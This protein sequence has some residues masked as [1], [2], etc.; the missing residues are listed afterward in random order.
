MAL[1]PHQ[2]PKPEELQARLGHLNMVQG[3]ISR[4]AGHSA[5]VKTFTLTIAAAI[6]AVAFEKNLP[7]LLWAGAV[8]TAMFGLLDAY[9]LTVEKCFR[10][11]YEEICARPWSQAFDF[12]IR[13]RRV[14]P[15]DVV[16]SITSI[17]VWGFY[18][19]LLASFAVLPQLLDHVQ[20]PA[21]S[22]EQPT[23]SVALPA[24]PRVGEGPVAASSKERHA[25]RAAAAAG[26]T[27]GSRLDVGPVR[28][29]AQRSDTS[30]Q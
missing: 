4:L 15:S 29:D 23:V 13:Q 21:P 11:L 30:P 18:P 20:R 7:T 6:V 14:K 25:E 3:I 27:P 17:S 9:Y 26:P 2:S 5:T 28:A 10:S 16:A 24:P 12:S 22:V 8:V 1:P 19:L